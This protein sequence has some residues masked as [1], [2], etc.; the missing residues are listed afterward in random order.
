MPLAATDE[1]SPEIAITPPGP[2][3]TEDATTPPDESAH[4]HVAGDPKVLANPR[5]L[6]V[7]DDQTCRRSL[8]RNLKLAGYQVLGAQDG[9]E[10]LEILQSHGADIVVTDLLMPNM[11]GVDLILN[12]VL[13]RPEIPII[14]I[15]G[16]NRQ[17]GRVRAARL[18]G[19]RAVLAKP[20]GS[21]ALVEAIAE[22]L[23][24]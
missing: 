16:T 14:A 10:A 13:D 1:R 24:R 8:S 22:A 15:T 4:T 23:E 6:V 3:T 2:F 21:N 18:F 9:V 19:A 7:E 5:V 12:L 11:D 20:F 17:D